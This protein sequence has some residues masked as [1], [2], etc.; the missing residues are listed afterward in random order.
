MHHRSC[1]IEEFKQ[2]EEHNLAT[3]ALLVLV[4]GDNFTV[5]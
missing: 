4:F 2:Q 5:A 1:P 3:C